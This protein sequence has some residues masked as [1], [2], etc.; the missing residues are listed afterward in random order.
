MARLYANENFPLPAVEE[1]RRLGHDVLTTRDAGKAEQA[2]PDEAVLA[3]AREQS[4]AL[5]TLNRRHFARLHDEQP[6]HC[7]IVVCS[8][9]PDFGALARRIDAAARSR[10]SLDGQLIRVQRPGG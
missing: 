7:G 10:A 1:L 8:L 2:I 6:G 4:R 5:L 3:F 9:D